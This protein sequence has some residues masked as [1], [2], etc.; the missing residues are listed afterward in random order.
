MY[1][2]KESKLTDLEKLE[3]KFDDIIQD[4]LERIDELEYVN[5][6]QASEIGDLNSDSRYA[7]NKIEDLQQEVSTLETRIDN[8]E[9]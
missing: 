5:D 2:I 9:D 1:T 6:R 3:D 7:H 4:L 8:M